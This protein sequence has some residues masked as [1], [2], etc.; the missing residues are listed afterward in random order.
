M[1][2][3][4]RPI[5]TLSRLLRRTARPPDT[6]P[7]ISPQTRHRIKTLIDALTYD[8]TQYTLDH[9]IEFLSD[10]HPRP[11]RLID[12]PAQQRVPVGLW[13]HQSEVEYIVVASGDHIH[14]LLREHIAL[15]ELGH[16]L[17]AHIPIPMGGFREI[18]RAWFQE[19]AYLEDSAEEIEAEYLAYYVQ[20]CIYQ[21]QF[22]LSS[23]EGMG[24]LARY[25]AFHDGGRR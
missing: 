13:Y 12:Y 15:H 8:F 2:K 6:L 4:H 19:R 24:I 23:I 25:L 9:F 10:R 16:I 7:K 17:L 14:P 20:L 5:L 22:R 18:G 1:A 11:I 3:P 21:H